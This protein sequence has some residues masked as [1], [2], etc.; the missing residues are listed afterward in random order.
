MAKTASFSIAPVKRT[1]PLRALKGMVR[2]LYDPV[3]IRNHDLVD[4]LR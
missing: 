1:E 2:P 4:L 3:I